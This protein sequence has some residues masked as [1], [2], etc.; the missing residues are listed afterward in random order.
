MSR[1]YSSRWVIGWGALYFEGYSSQK[2]MQVSVPITN[3]S[4]CIEKVIYPAKQVCAGYD[5]GGSDSCQGDSGGPL[6]LER[7]DGSF[8]LIGVVS[9]GVGCARPNKPGKMEMKGESHESAGNPSIYFLSST[10]NYE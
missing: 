5:L 8:E 1:Y 3:N 4:G 7:S 9:F 10:D 6:L 2:L